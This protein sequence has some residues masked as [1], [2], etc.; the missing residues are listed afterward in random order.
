MR[1]DGS[2]RDVGQ[3]GTLLGFISDVSLTETRFRLKPGDTLL[4]Y[5]DGATEARRPAGGGTAERPFF[6]EEALV[7]ALADSRGRSAQ[8]IIR[9]LGQLLADHTAHWASDDTALLALRVPTGLE[10]D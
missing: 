9:H 4:L 10:A 6:G 1:A 7:R 5:T 8:A 3:I 2:V